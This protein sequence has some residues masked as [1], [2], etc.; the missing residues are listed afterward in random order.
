MVAPIIGPSSFGDLSNV[1]RANQGVGR[2]TD[3]ASSLRQATF[4]SM[5]LKPGKIKKSKESGK[6]FTW[7]CMVNGSGSFGM[8]PMVY[9]DQLSNVD[10][11]AVAS[12]DWRH[13]KV[14]WPEVAQVTAMNTGSDVQIASTRML[15]EKAAMI[16]AM[17]GLEAQFWQSP[18]GVSDTLSLWGINIW[19]PRPTSYTADG[20]YGTVPSGYTT[21]G[22]NPTTYPNWK[23]YYFQYT[24]VTDEDF[25]RRLAKA[26]N[27][28][29]FESLVEGIPQFNTDLKRVFFSNYGLIGPLQEL[30]K[31]SNENLGLDI[32][33][34]LGK[35]VI[36]GV[37]VI[38]VPYLDRETTNPI[39]GVNVDD[40][41]MAYL[42]GFW[43][44]PL[45]IPNMP[46]FHNVA[47]NFR[48]TTCQLIVRNRRKS[49][50][51]ATSIT[52]AA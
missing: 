2:V 23:N 33:K 42:D 3:I 41:E 28:T 12:A 50:I 29:S 17:E 39:Y 47:G 19:L 6:S 40:F 10:T 16:S 31:S 11:T 30:L 22:L 48:D 46:G 43:M 24:N 5:L 9:A 34:Y 35:P 13:W 37:P 52:Y 36:S 51:G 20:F 45:R 44:K 32:T 4:M 15:Q 26:I 38:N 7:T 49:L 18:V 8:V 21:V 14:D 27:D 1:T 25:V